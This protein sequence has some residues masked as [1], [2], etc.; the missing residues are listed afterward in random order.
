MHIG[1]RFLFIVTG[2]VKYISDNGMS[3][4]RHQA[5][6]RTNDRML[7]IGPLG[8]IYSEILIEIYIFLFKEMHM[9]CRQE[10]DAHFGS[11]SVF[12]YY[13]VQI[14]KPHMVSGLDY[15]TRFSRKL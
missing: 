10:A 2:K 12:K 6:I 1:I 14:E 7:F 3:P 4:G 5:I 9:K 13:Q 15:I 8:T 11:A